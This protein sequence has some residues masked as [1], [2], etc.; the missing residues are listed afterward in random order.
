MEQMIRQL[1]ND[2]FYDLQEACGGDMDAQD[3]ADCVGD[4]MCDM[5]EEYRNTPWEV[6]RK[7]TLKIAREYV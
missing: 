3:L 7:M 2:V 4:R 1:I 6:R 5:S